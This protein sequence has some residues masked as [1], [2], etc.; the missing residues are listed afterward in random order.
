MSV[1]SGALLQKIYVRYKPKILKGQI[2]NCCADYRKNRTVGFGIFPAGL[3]LYICHG[4][5]GFFYALDLY[6]LFV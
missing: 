5:F 6:Y 3:P 1:S 4:G 2:D